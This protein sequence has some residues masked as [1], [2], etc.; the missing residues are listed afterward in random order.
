MVASTPHWALPARRRWLSRHSLRPRLACL[1]AVALALLLLAL[2]PSAAFGDPTPFAT[3]TATCTGASDTIVTFPA[4]S[5]EHPD[6]IFSLTSAG[7]SG[8]V[9]PGQ[10]LPSSFFSL[11]FSAGDEIWGMAAPD[12][13]GV[14]SVAVG[15][16]GTLDIQGCNSGSVSAQLYDRPTAPTTI[17]GVSSGASTHSDLP[18]IARAAGQY[19]VDVTIDQG[20]IQLNWADSSSEDDTMT[21]ASSGEYSLGSLAAGD[22]DILVNGLSGPAAH[23]SLAVHELPVGISGLSFGPAS[24]AAPGTIL[25]GSFS[26]SGDTT[27]SAYVRNGNGQVVRHLGSFAVKQGSSSI[28]W[29]TRGD[30]G[31]TLPDGAYYLHLDSTDPNGNVTSAETSILVDGTPPAVSMTSPGTITPSQSV[32]FSIVDSGSGVASASV[33]IDGQDVADFGAY[34][35]NPLP[36]NGIIGFAP[37]YGSWNLG[38]HSWEVQATDNVG[39]AADVTGGFL[40]A[41]PPPPP[42]PPAPIRIPKVPVFDGAPYHGKGL[43]EKPYQIVYTGDGTGVLAGARRGSGKR[44]AWGHLKWT[45]WTATEAL[46]SGV[47]W[48]DN[49]TPDCAG[50]KFNGYPVKIRLYRAQYEHNNEVFTRMALY[51]PQKRPPFQKSRSVTLKVIFNQGSFSWS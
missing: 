10:W 29:D 37:D 39:N 32:S 50:G 43:Q 46:G 9:W 12:G 49:C 28:T 21:I 3:A 41:N 34:T 15:T 30:G 1:S 36:P 31:A 40:V 16:S 51:Y 38:S 14:W 47:S 13:M 25:T 48:V 7:A 35:G 11:Q 44:P 6:S 33:Y 2:P 4:Q 26:V 5:S 19:V 20:A 23:Y 17:S 42:K 27:I 18:F 24:Y 22:Q 8:A 45:T